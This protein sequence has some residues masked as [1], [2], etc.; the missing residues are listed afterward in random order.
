MTNTDPLPSSL[1]LERD[2]IRVGLIIG[3]HSTQQHP[4]D[5]R[6]AHILE[7]VNLVEEVGLDLVV[8]EDALLHKGKTQSA[9]VWEAEACQQST[10]STGQSHA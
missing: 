3:L 6:W 1:T 2:P 4:S 9:G 10:E 5:K 7:Q 8:F